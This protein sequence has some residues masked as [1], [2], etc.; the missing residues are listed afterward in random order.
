M[1]RRIFFIPMSGVCFAAAWAAV[2]A[3]EFPGLDREMCYLTA[4]GFGAAGAGSAWVGLRPKKH[5]CRERCE[6]CGEFL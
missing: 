2:K 3:S 6:D 4:A 5:E 1:L